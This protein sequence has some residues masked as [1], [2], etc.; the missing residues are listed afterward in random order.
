MTAHLFM[1]K[2]I[3][4]VH[5]LRIGVNL[6][7]LHLGRRH[8]GRRD[9]QQ[10]RPHHAASAPGRGLRQMCIRDSYVSA[11]PADYELMKSEG[12]IVE[13]LIRP[14]G[15]VDPPLEVRIT[16]NQICLLYTSRCV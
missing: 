16:D 11:T 6:G 13:Q 10:V 4:P 14:T 5:G 9:V 12:V 7:Y 3:T 15:L 1:G 2:W 8:A